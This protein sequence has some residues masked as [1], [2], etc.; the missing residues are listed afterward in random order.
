[1]TSAVAASIQAVSPVSTFGIAARTLLMRPP[2]SRRRGRSPRPDAHGALE[3]DHEDLAVADV[4][5]A[6]RFA[7][8]AEGALHE[9]VRDGD[10]EADL[11]RQPHL[12]GRP[13][14]GL[15]PLE[16]SPVA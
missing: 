10:L 3:R 7:D 16:L 8:G 6:G 5:G 4:A 13:A 11:V 1:M 14:V 15:D 2:A 9:L 12:H